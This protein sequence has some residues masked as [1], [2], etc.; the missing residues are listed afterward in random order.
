MMNTEEYINTQQTPSL[1]TCEDLA[2]LFKYVNTSFHKSGN[3]THDKYNTLLRI[4]HCISTPYPG[5]QGLKKWITT[6]ILVMFLICGLLGN[7]ISAIIMFRRSRR[8]LSSYFYLALL[9]VMDICVLYSGCLLSILDITF[10]YHPELH[11]TIYCR[12]SFYIKHLFTYLS[13]WL[14]VA[15]TFERLIVVRF[16][17]QSIHICRLRVAYGIAL[18]I[19][20]F[21]SL[22]TVHVFFTIDIEHIHLRRNDGYHPDYTVCDLVVH[23]RLFAFLDLCFY[24]VIPS[25]CI[26]ICNIL[27][28]VTM[29]YA[30]KQRRDDLQASMGPST[31][32]TSPGNLGQKNKSSS[33]ISTSLFRNRPLGEC[34]SSIDFP[35]TKLTVSVR[36]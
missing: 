26:T 3:M 2:N 17:F 16:P 30:I 24:S 36:N 15:V 10:G 21:F 6:I 7:M 34:S 11:A 1:P 29:F 20:I 12:L 25:L 22:Y 28:I 18:T 35:Q 23:R 8:G 13:A 32:E 19:L 33:S 4:L 14:I 31:T 5:V 9:A 27:I